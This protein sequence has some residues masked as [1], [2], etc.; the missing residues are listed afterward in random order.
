MNIFD[1]GFRGNFTATAPIDHG[2]FDRSDSGWHGIESDRNSYAQASRG[3]DGGGKGCL[4]WIFAALVIISVGT[5]WPWRYL[6]LDQNVLKT[7]G[8]S[9]TVI[10]GV[11]SVVLVL[12]VFVGFLQS[13]K[14]PIYW[15]VAAWLLVT[16]G[17][18]LRPMVV[19]AKNGIRADVRGSFIAVLLALFL[20]PLVMRVM[21]RLLKRP[22]LAHVAM[23]LAFGFFLNVAQLLA[24]THVPAFSWLA[25]AN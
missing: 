19:G 22:G 23:P 24:A 15:E 10:L 20:L 21:N 11:V 12:T 8:I 16:I 4:S 9:A 3:R 13:M 14:N 1:L 25:G 7:I 5:R 17:I 18:L 6:G 2:Q